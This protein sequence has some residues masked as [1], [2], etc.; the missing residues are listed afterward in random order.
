VVHLRGIVIAADS[1]DGLTCDPTGQDLTVSELPEGYRPARQEVHA[2]IS[3]EQLGRVNIDPD[4]KVLAGE[5]TSN[6]VANAKVWLSL[7][8]IAFGP[9]N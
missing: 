6:S 1:G 3:N 7:D 9:A 5:D 8:G 2:A 4:E